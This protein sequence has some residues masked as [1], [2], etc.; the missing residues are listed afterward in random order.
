MLIV[1]ANPFLNFLQQLFN[2]IGS[3]FGHLMPQ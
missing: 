2:F 1:P 3:L